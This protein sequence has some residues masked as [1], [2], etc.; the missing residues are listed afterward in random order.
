MTSELETRINDVL[1]KLAMLAEGATVNL[2]PATSHGKPESSLPG[3]LNQD[4][5]H[6]VDDEPDRRT[7][8]PFEW[9]RWRFTEAILREEAELRIWDLCLYAEREYLEQTLP[10]DH[11][12]RLRSGQLTENDIRD[13]GVAEREAA[14]R[15][16][17]HY[18][19]KRA[20][21]VAVWEYTT[22]A[23]IKKARRMNGRNPHD[24]TPR[25]EFL[26]LSE[27]ER[28]QVAIGLKARGMKLTKAADRLRVDKNT[29][30]RYWPA[31]E[32]LEEAA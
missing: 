22:E 30:K 13:G 25:A 12:R 6:S 3:G 31:D 7:A 26:D 21:E 11:R 4:L 18:E 16:V 27:D 10:D 29:L 19:G 15:I 9:W 28:R 2:D 14:K 5:D 20:A 17:D 1:S 8:T 23:V 24:G 32:E